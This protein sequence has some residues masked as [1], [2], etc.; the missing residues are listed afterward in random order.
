MER[1]RVLGIM[2]SPRSG[3]NT[4][5]LLDAA[6]SGAAEA[7]AQTE[8]VLVA[9]MR[10]L[11]CLELYHCAVD[12]TCSIQDDM[13]G[14]YDALVAADCIILASPVFFYG[15]TSQ[16]KAV[17]DRCQALWV[18]RHVLKTWSPD[19]RSRRGA[20]IAVGAT[21]GPRLFDGVTLTGKYFFDAVG[22]HEAGSLLVRGVD[23]K[24]AVLDSPDYIEKARLLGTDLASEPGSSGSL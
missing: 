1:I 3:S 13:R 12:G 16:A 17:V 4:E 19:I 9:R 22:V 20:L 7:G 24:A 23:G 14:L 21:S 8:K 5:I 15:L 2:G 10:I 18:R 11:P 6:L